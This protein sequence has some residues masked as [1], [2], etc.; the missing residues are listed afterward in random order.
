M[1]RMLK[2]AAVVANGSLRRYLPR[3]V[4]DTRMRHSNRVSYWQGGNPGRHGLDDLL[5]T[6]VSAAECTRLENRAYLDLSDLPH[7][8]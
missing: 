8:V 1:R 5:S 2:R 7:G 6:F 3:Q 4:G